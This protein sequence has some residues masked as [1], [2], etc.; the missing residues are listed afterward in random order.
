MRRAARRALEPAGH[1]A[2]APAARAVRKAPP[3]TCERSSFAAMVSTSRAAWKARSAATRCEAHSAANSMSSAST[4]LSSRSPVPSPPPFAAAAACS[5]SCSP[6]SC[7]PSH[8]ASA[9]SASLAAA[10]AASASARNASVPLPPTHALRER[11]G[12]KGV[13]PPHASGTWRTRCQWYRG[14]HNTSPGASSA[15]SAVALARPGQRPRS[16]RSGSAIAKLSAGWPVGYGYRS[17]EQ[18]GGYTSTLF[19]PS[20]CARKLSIASKWQGVMPTP[21]PAHSCR[22]CSGCDAA[23][24]HAECSHAQPRSRSS[25]S[26]A[27]GVDWA[28]PGLT[29]GTWR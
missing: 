7:S 26:S 27:T 1:E 3:S 19:L 12:E 18:C 25:A 11:L 13:A 16:G 15:S 5:C 6:C 14:S 29:S 9:A 28:A 24:S 17:N 23:A 4:T 20:S 8:T 10:Y 21:W 2:S 22:A